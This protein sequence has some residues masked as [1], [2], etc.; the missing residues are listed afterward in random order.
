MT[1]FALSLAAGV[2]AF[3]FY[4]FFPMTVCVVSVL[5][6]LWT[7]LVRHFPKGGGYQ[8]TLSCKH[9]LILVFAFGFLYAFARE[10]H[11]PDIAF[12][13]G[14]LLVA[15][16]VSD[17]PERRGST[18]RFTLDNASVE[19]TGIEGTV[20]LTALTEMFGGQ[21]HDALLEPGVRVSAV[22]RLSEPA[23]YRN[24]G[25]F[26]GR[27]EGRAATGYVKAMMVLDRE[28]GRVSWTGRKRRQLG[29]VIDASLS[30]EN[31]SFHRAIIAGLKRGISPDMRDAF[32]ATGLAHL[33]SI[34]GTHF[35][36]LAFLFFSV[37]RMALKALP[38]KYFT[39]MTLFITPT[40]T[41]A[42]VTT[43]LLAAYA[44]LSGASTP[45]IRSFIMV[46]ISM[47]AL[48]LG[49]RGRWLNSLSLAAVVLLLWLPAFLFE[50][51]F[52]LSF[53]AVLSIGYAL[54]RKSLISEQRTG[55]S[56]QGRKKRTSAAFRIS[57]RI[58]T[59]FLITVAALLGTAPIVS[60]CFNQFPLMSPV[61][62]L[63]ITPIVCFVIL[64]VGVISAFIA[65]IFNLPVLPLHGLIDVLSH[66]CLWLIR[67]FSGIPY[68][69]LYVH[70]P[71]G[72]LVVLY[73]LALLF[74]AKGTARWRFLPFILVLCL[75]QAIPCVSGN[76]LRVT[77]LDVGQ[78]DASVVELPDAKTMLIDGGAGEPDM[79][80]AVIAPWL[81]SRGIKKIDYLVLSHPHPDHFGGVLY[82]LD[83]FHVGEIWYNG[84]MPA[85]AGAFFQSAL[86][87]G[88][89]FRGLSRGDALVQERYRIYALHP[90][91]GFFALSPRG[92]FSDE[93]SRSLVLKLESPDGSFLFTGDIE[94]EAEESLVPLGRWLMSDVLK[95]SHHGGRTS[96]SGAFID[97]VHPRIAVA[98]A[99]RM[100]GFHHPHQE[101][102]ERLRSV[103]AR[104]FRTDRDGAVTITAKKGRFEIATREDGQFIRAGTWRDEL[105]NLAL[106]FR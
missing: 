102:L 46:L 12:P 106:L 104:I 87:R 92:E 101:T 18:I 31:A 52:L 24:A 88:M 26:S 27:A 7:G 69:R 93:N 97:A 53:S 55:N 81:W 3:R 91:D 32:S 68:S 89:P 14:D 72:A 98:S 58:R 86:R 13:A 79:G 90:F 49:R 35:G 9:W 57:D 17:V 95:V 76:D 42:A 82:L 29:T 19:R 25:L 37:I 28:D 71:P 45:T 21:F 56:E 84:S 77:F 10:E 2:A 51:S 48:L 6:A 5:W 1:G 99:G 94:E 96:S 23:V 80:R 43:P 8:G 100:N 54:D 105:R 33:L 61:T 67:L 70:A 11:L 63:V 85:E 103:N 47:S 22:A 40:Q 66:A 50:V 36:L 65:L 15:G 74:I 78:G 4:P 75:Y 62:N 34:S 44:V 83:K 16:T 30:P 73:Y 39:V 59:A 38:A 41:A 60:L 20:G 64:P